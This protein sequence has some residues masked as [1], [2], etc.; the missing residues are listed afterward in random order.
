MVEWPDDKH[1][2]AAGTERQHFLRQFADAIRIRGAD[3]IFF[4]QNVSRLPVDQRRS[5]DKDGNVK[6]RVADSLEHVVCA[7]DVHAQSTDRFRPRFPDVCD[8]GAVIDDGW[9]Q[10]SKCIGDRLSIQQVNRV[11]LNTAVAREVWFTLSN[12]CP[13]GHSGFVFEKMIDE[14][15]AGKPGRARYQRRTTHGSRQPRRGPYCAS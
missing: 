1:G 3:W 12:V 9:P 6:A 7:E 15:A 11:P 14:V 4:A 10:T 8:P 2:R 5:R 13:G